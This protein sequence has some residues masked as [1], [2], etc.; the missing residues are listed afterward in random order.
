MGCPP[1]V[2]EEEEQNAEQKLPPLPTTAVRGAQQG[3]VLTGGLAQSGDRG[4]FSKEMA[5]MADLQDT[6]LEGAS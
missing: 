6:L 3:A 4:G 1:Q 2:S 5:L